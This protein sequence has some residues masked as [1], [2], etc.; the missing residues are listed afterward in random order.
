MKGGFQEMQS[1]ILQVK[2]GKINYKIIIIQNFEGFIPH[3]TIILTYMYGT[4]QYSTE[5]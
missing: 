1:L 2:S 3:F 4:Q 5:K